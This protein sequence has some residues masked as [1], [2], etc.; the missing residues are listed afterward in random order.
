LILESN[1][2][3]QIMVLAHN[4]SL[5][6]YLY[7]AIEYQGFATRG[8]YI[9]GMKERDLR[10]TEDQQIV[11]ATYAMAAE[12]LDIKT[13]SI[14]VMVTPKVDI[15]QSVGRILRERHSNP[16]VVDIIDRHETFQNQWRK[17]K[18]F[19]RKCNYRILKTTSTKYNGFDPS[20][21]SGWK[22]EF[23]PRVE[24]LSKDCFG[25]DSSN[26]IHKKMEESEEVKCVLKKPAG[27]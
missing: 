1:G 7:E 9:G 17:R 25:N 4:R 6:K 2:E 8:Y 5:L 27:F 19:Y 13:L 23:E 16:I 11:L 21:L 3:G 14:L 24:E 12:A 26:Q 22:T 10:E 18:T 20:E 15:E